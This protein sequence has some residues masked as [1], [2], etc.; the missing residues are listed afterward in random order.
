MPGLLQG[1]SGL[2]DPAQRDGDALQARH[3]N[4]MQQIGKAS[5][6]PRRSRSS[7]ERATPR[8]TGNR[9]PA[10]ASRQAGSEA[11]FCTYPCGSEPMEEAPMPSPP[12][13]VVVPGGE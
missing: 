3:G 2:L 7:A 8:A 9:S 5:I 4:A 6:T 11:W 1:T 13:C 10:I 12:H